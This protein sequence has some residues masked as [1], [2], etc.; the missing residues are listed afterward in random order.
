[1]TFQLT[2]STSWLLNSA[3]HIYS[4]VKRKPNHLFKVIQ[5][6]IQKGQNIWP[7]PTSLL[8]LQPDNATYQS[9]LPSSYPPQQQ[10]NSSYT[11]TSTC[12]LQRTVVCLIRCVDLFPN[13]NVSEPVL[14]STHIRPIL[15]NTTCCFLCFAFFSLSSS[16]FTTTVAPSTSVYN[17]VYIHN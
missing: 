13:Q 3:S 6:V 14:R 1:M 10:L 7:L 8:E 17:Y 4:N 5:L 12:L 11:K 15:L 16:T 2:K 9:Y